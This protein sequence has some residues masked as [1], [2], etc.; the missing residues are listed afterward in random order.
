ML[1]GLFFPI[2]D[3]QAGEP[4][5]QFR[6]LTPVGEPLQYSYFLACGSSTQQLRDL[7]I[8]Q[9]CPFYHLIVTPL[10]SLG[11]GYLC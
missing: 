8:W 3:P 10:F 2:P 11:I 5:L 7:L 4:D 1:W 6:I 9:K